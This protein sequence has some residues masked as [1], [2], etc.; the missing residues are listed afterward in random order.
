MELPK[1][2]C[3]RMKCLLGEEYSA[4]EAA[5]QEEA[6]TAIRINTAKV[7]LA[8][9]QEICPFETV[10]VPWNRKGF[11]TVNPEENPAKHPYY[12]AG[13]YYIQEPSAMIPAELLPVE[14][15]D[16]VL[17]L[18]A[19]PG[20]K[21]TELAAKLN[22]TGI[23]LANDI[24]VSRGMALAKNLQVAGAANAVVT[25]EAPEKL[26]EHFGEY[27]DGILVDAPCSGEGM[28]RREPRMVQ[29]WLE[30]GPDYYETIQKDILTSAYH[31]L[32]QGGYLVY[33]TCTFAPQEDEGMLLWLLRTFP[34]LEICT[35]E[36]KQGFSEGRPDWIEMADGPLPT[37]QEREQI[38]HAVRIFP[39]RTSGEGHFAALLRKHASAKEQHT[40]CESINRKGGKSARGKNSGY[41]GKA[42]AGAILQEAE[43]F[44]ELAGFSGQ[45]VTMKKEQCIVET[46]MG[47]RLNGLRCIQTGLIA[48]HGAKRFEPSVQLALAVRDDEAIPRVRLSVDD[49][50]VMRYLKGETLQEITVVGEEHVK[51]TNGYVLICVDEFPLG[52][53]KYM[54]NGTVRNKYYAGWRMQ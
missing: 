36:R 19:A 40:V 33:S 1:S 51:Q 42:D 6:H 24:S 21:A 53:G 35:V 5:L 29:D 12:Y 14:A 28:F 20:G 43:H 41:K 9:W 17:D 44:V 39:H 48:G 49:L 52:W 30:R 18:C 31:M 3:E 23:L 54:G 2:Y 47:N 11:M 26:S 8:K 37:D 34:D 10:E 25:A 7:S 15:G 50:R 4:Y 27:F 13:L 32:K 45:S 46:D 38:Q 16:R 22:G